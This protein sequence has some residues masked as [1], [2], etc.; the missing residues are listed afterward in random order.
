[1]IRYP[2]ELT[3]QTEEPNVCVLDMA[4][5][6]LDDGSWQGIEEILRLDNKLR[7]ELGY[8]LR[9]EAYP[10]PW[11]LS[12]QEEPEHRI[13]L[14]FCIC[15]EVELE[16]PVLALEHP[17]EAQV[18]LNGEAVLAEPVGFYVDPS[19]ETIKLNK[20]YAGINELILSW[21]YSARR[22]IEAV[23]LLGNFDVYL[24]GKGKKLIPVSKDKGFGDI[25][26]QGLPFYGGNLSYQMRFTAKT[27]EFEI[28][29]PQYRGSLLKVWVDGKE[30][31][32]IIFSPYKL[33]VSDITPGEH[34]I[35]I[36]LYG[37]R[38]NTFGA[39]HNCDRRA[40]MDDWMGPNAW[41][42]EGARWSYEYQLKEMGILTAPMF[43]EKSI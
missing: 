25:V 30:Q 5:Y 43:L 31:G 7:N 37:N 27:G 26:R 8:P 9:T 32:N 34:Q 36:R 1:M 39:L 2:E 3:L 17:E 22:N 24:S 15:S 42:T 29:V 14:R 16:N 40:A 21:P 4:E 20:I 6:R 10:Q 18:L 12:G 19:I 41:R 23:Y 35:M 13:S 28:W 33:K 38:A 11:I